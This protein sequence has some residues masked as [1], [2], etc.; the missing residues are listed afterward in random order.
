MRDAIKDEEL[1]DEV[2]EVER[3]GGDAG[4]TRKRVQKLVEDR[5]TAPA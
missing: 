4:D 1:A 5:Y 3:A 2:A